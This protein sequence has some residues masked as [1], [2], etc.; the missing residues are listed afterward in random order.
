VYLTACP[1]SINSFIHSKVNILQGSSDLR[2]THFVPAHPISRYGKPTETLPY[3]V[4][5]KHALSGTVL[6]EGDQRCVCINVC[7]GGW[8]FVSCVYKC[9]VGG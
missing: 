3:S 8:V 9:V 1:F 5:V 7:V 4:V 6:W 2:N